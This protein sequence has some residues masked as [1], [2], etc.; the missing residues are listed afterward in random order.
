MLASRILRP[1]AGAQPPP[2]QTP[3]APPTLEAPCLSALRPLPHSLA[4]L[5][6]FS[7]VVASIWVGMECQTL[8]Q[9]ALKPFLWE[10]CV[11]KELT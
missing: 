2:T 4:L 11:S 6:W 5:L 3:T 7:E 1:S 10:E 8:V 9:W